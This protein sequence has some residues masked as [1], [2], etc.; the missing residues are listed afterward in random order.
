MPKRIG[1]Q[2]DLIAFPA[3]DSVIAG[4]GVDHKVQ[5]SK[6]ASV[7]LSLRPLAIRNTARRSWASDL[8]TPALIRR[9]DC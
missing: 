3:F 6:I 4:A 7:G 5:L 8:K 9:R 1:R 2:I